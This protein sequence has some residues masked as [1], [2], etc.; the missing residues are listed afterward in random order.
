MD[1]FERN[2]ERIIAVSSPAAKPI[3]V[4]GNTAVCSARALPP[5]PMVLSLPYSRIPCI[6]TGNESER[7]AAFP[8]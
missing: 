3:R 4:A 2:P 1:F 7:K 8:S 5:A 6:Q